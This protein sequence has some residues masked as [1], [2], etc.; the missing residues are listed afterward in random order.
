LFS[1][2]THDL[3]LITAALNESGIP[4]VG[5]P[6]AATTRDGFFLPPLRFTFDEAKALFISAAMLKAQAAGAI[7]SEVE[8]A[9]AKISSVM[10]ENVRS[11]AGRLVEIIQFVAPPQPFTLDNPTLLQIQQAILE[12]RGLHLVY[13]SLQDMHN[14]PPDRT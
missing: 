13:Q 4:I 1:Q 12:R 7:S 3:S 10:P 11:E 2:R 5:L 6:G 9:I 14:H 8:M